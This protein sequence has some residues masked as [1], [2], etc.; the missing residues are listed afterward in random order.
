M[1]K[2]KNFKCG[3]CNSEYS[4]SLELDASDLL[5]FKCPVCE[6]EHTNESIKKDNRQILLD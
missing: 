6:K 5:K 2:I 1:E 4:F 3:K